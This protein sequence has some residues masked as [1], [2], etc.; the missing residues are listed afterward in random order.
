MLPYIRSN[1]S[2]YNHIAEGFFNTTSAAHTK[3]EYDKLMLTLCKRWQRELT[4]ENV[5][6]YFIESGEMEPDTIE[7]IKRFYKTTR[8]HFRKQLLTLI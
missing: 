3:E 1:A 7:E 4:D 6:A 8:N 2:F 5:L